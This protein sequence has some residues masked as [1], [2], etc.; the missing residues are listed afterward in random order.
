MESAVPPS[1]IAALSSGEFVGMIGDNPD[2]KIELKTF[3]CEIINDHEKLKKETDNYRPILTFRAIDNSIMQLNYMQI[4]EDIQE[5]IYAEMDRLA[6]NPAL[7][8]L[9]IKKQS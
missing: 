2:E 1:K 8:H 6:N 7:Q 4:K 3:H 9:V 5:M